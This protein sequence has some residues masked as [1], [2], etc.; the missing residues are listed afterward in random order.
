MYALYSS[1]FGS[2]P[3][4]RTPRHTIRTFPS[5]SADSRVPCAPVPSSLPSALSYTLQR[6]PLSRNRACANSPARTLCRTACTRM[7]RAFVRFACMHP[8]RTCWS[9]ISRASSLSSPRTPGRILHM[10]IAFSLPF[11]SIPEPPALVDR[12]PLVAR[13]ADR[14]KVRPCH[15]IATLPDRLDVVYDRRRREPSLLP[16]DPAEWF[17]FQ[18]LLPQ[19]SPFACVVERLALVA[20][21]P[22]ASRSLGLRLVRRAVL[23]SGL[24]SCRASGKPARCLWFLRHL[25]VS[26][27]FAP[28]SFALSGRENGKASALPNLR[29]TNRRTERRGL[30]LRRPASSGDIGI[31]YRKRTERTT[32]RFFLFFLFWSFCKQT[33]DSFFRRVRRDVRL[34]RNP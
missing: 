1:I 17:F 28:C 12:L 7:L 5:V 30:R 16:A 15:F 31:S 26:P 19:S 25:F 33:I 9:S 32:F 2:P 8:S 27:S 10:C 3:F 22:L 21:Q 23:F 34:Q 24:R 11:A 13:S 14:L 6:I 18:D 4:S 20:F 29:E